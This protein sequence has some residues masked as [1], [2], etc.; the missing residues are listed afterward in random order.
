MTAGAA[1]MSPDSAP[2]FG[3]LL[4]YRN[5]IVP[6]L[7]R[8]SDE[9]HEHGAAAMIQITFLRRRAVWNKAGVFS[10]APRGLKQGG[11]LP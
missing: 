5:E 4:A 1:V 9:C 3:N 8:L 10:E 7:R 2:V 6:R 11:G